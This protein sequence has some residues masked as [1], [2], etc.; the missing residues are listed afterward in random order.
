MPILNER[1]IYLKDKYK[2]LQKTVA[3]Q[4]NI[5]LR[6]Y[7]RYE[8]GERE[9]PI[10][11]LIKLADFFNVSLDYLTGRTNEPDNPNLKK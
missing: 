2:L 9:P 6:T 10:S 11:T 5:N 8:T 4:N 1:L 7:Q 3:E